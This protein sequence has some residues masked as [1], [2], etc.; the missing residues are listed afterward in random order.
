[1]QKRLESAHR[2]WLAAQSEVADIVAKNAPADSPTDW[3]E[4]YR[5]ATRLATIAEEWIVEKND[6]QHPVLFVQQDAYK[7]FIVDNPDVRYHF[8]VLDEHQS[9]RL[10]GNRG[11]A[12]YVGLTFGSDIFHWG[13]G[14]GGGGT[15]SQSNLDDFELDEEGNFEIIISPEKHQGNWIEMV[16]D[17]QHLAIRETFFDKENQR[18]AVL[19]MER[20][21]EPIPAPRLT[22]ETFAEKL[23][24]AA[25]FMVFVAQTCVGMYAGTMKN[26][27]CITGAP[28]QAHVDAQ[29]DE[30]DTHCSTEMLYMGGRWK[31]EEDQAL[32]VTVKPPPAEFTYWGLVLVN[33]WAESYDYRFAP[34]CTNNHRAHA[35]SDG[36]W[37]LVIAAQDPGVPNW[38]DTGGRLEGQML[39]RWCLAPLSTENPDCELVPL[40]AVADRIG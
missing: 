14:G 13:Q 5:W 9:Y 3:A 24:L 40:Q 21:G 23:E 22:P 31:I 33:P 26:M 19:H 15:L 7:K 34:T 27:N 1:M 39:M 25:N 4:G 8:C 28:G 10:W 16:A 35:G 18:G 30:V 37:R 6:P 38:L 20:L 11:E 12:P 29:K 32:I 36:A 2:T 17:I